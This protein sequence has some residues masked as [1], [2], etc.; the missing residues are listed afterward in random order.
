MLLDSPPIDR[1][2][3]DQRVLYLSSGRY[4]DDA[5]LRAAAG[6]VLSRL[7]EL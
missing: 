7:G 3:P 6:R 5:T 2:R 1:P 4:V